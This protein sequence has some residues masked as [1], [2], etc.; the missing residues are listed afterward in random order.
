MPVIV[1]LER[2]RSL[3]VL[4]WIREAHGDEV[5]A[6]WANE[7]TALPGRPLSEEL[8]QEGLSLALGE[9]TIGELVAKSYRSRW[10]VGV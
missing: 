6:V 5:A 7:C 2:E 1:D 3:I 10:S 8:L 4:R 9:V